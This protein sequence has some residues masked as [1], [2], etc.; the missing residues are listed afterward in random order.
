L[1]CQRLGE[2]S[3]EPGRIG[4]GSTVALHAPVML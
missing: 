3:T 1:D 2:Q 4:H